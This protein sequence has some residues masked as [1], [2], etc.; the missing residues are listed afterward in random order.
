MKETTYVVMDCSSKY[1]VWIQ[2]VIGEAL[3]HT[4]L[5]VRIQ[6]AEVAETCAYH[7]TIHCKIAKNFVH[8][9]DGV[10]VPSPLSN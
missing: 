3:I 2:N 1:T 9:Q 7:L 10:L 4:P 6:L 8:F 5:E